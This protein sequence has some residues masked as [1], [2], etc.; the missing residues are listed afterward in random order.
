[1]WCTNCG[2]A[3]TEGARFCDGCGAPVAQVSGERQKR[4]SVFEGKIHK[5]PHCGETLPSFTAVCPVCKREIRGGGA[6]EAVGALSLALSRARNQAEKIE[7]IKTFPV[8]NS[9][10]DIL[11]F[12]L[13]ASSNFDAE[14]Y[15]THLNEEDLS[16]AWLAKIEQCYRK[17]KLSGNR[18]F[19]NEVEQAYNE[20]QE[21]I[22]QA[23]TSE[24]KTR[25]RKKQQ[26]FWNN[27]KTAIFLFG[28]WGIILL[29]G[30]I[31]GLNM[32]N[33]NPNAI[34]VGYSVEDLV[35]LQYDV[36]QTLLEE[37]GFENFLLKE[38]N[39]INLFNDG[40]VFEISIN[41]HTGFLSFSK[42][43]PDDLIVIHY[44]K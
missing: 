10:E 21:K 37:K 40:Q 11:E 9:R 32:C 27:K 24:E 39:D 14:Y 22:Q 34:S 6:S 17:A 23:K 36:V 7:I 19:L 3:L 15:A 35:G 29:I 8:P 2:K 1:M 25:K 18:A 41:G 44:Y 5:C 33:F 16:D 20:I 28:F 13:L 31:F 43:N 4:E 26:A 38:Q 12:M 30:C 42:F